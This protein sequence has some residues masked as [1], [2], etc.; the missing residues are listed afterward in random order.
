[1]QIPGET[2]SSMPFPAWVW[3]LCGLTMPCAPAYNGGA[4]M[5][6]RLCA[7]GALGGEYRRALSGPQLAWERNA[8]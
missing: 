8:A 6:D 2:A 7:L 3:R 4:V 1:V 5:N